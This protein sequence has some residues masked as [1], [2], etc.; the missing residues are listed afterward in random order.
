MAT[1]QKEGTDPT[2]VVTPVVVSQ[3]VPGQE[4]TPVVPEAAIVADP[5]APEEEEVITVSKA[6]Y[7]KLK[8]RPEITQEELADIRKNAAAGD[9]YKADMLKFKSQLH[10]LKGKADK[11]EADQTKI[12]ELEGMLSERSLK[13]YKLENLPDAL[14]PF[15]SFITGK[16]EDEMK[17]AITSFKEKLESITDKTVEKTKF[18]VKVTATHNPSKDLPATEPK[19]AEEKIEEGLAARQGH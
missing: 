4:A 17:S 11:T 6:E 2:V 12:T 13:L 3:V 16:T 14:R 7:E 1:K 18:A 9:E 19:T 8:L 5:A 10:E 15:E